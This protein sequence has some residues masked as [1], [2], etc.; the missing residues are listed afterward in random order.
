VSH[1]LDSRLL[2]ESES[3]DLMKLRLDRKGKRE[4]KK[5][6]AVTQ[7]KKEYRRALGVLMRAQKRRVKDI[8][9][10]LNVPIDAVERWLRAYRKRGIEGIDEGRTTDNVE[11]GLGL[12]LRNV[13]DEELPEMVRGGDERCAPAAL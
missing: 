12:H 11:Q 3:L 6:L 9:R 2:D 8:A 10:E 5:L 7:D 4:L 1:L 13:Q